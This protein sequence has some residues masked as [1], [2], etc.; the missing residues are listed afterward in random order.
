MIIFNF[1][2]ILKFDLLHTVGFFWVVG[3]TTEKTVNRTVRA[4]IQNYSLAT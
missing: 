2:Q 1:L 3:V 4:D